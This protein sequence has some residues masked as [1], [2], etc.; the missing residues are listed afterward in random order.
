MTQREPPN[1]GASLR[2]CWKKFANP[3]NGSPGKSR[4]K[5]PFPVHGKGID[6]VDGHSETVLPAPPKG[7][8]KV[9]IQGFQHGSV[10]GYRILPTKKMP[11]SVSSPPPG[12]L[13]FP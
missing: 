9:G 8:Y 13:L 2:N 6:A 11:L 12:K 3:A 10:P 1:H 4:Q 5:I 7:L